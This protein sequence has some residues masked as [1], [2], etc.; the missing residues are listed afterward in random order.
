MIVVAI[1][2]ILAAIAV[3]AYQNYLIR[4]QVTEGLALADGWKTAVAEFYA[5]YGVF[6]S[7]ASATGAAPAGGGCGGSVAALSN[8][9]TGK[10]AT[11][12]VGA[13]GQIR[14]T[15]NGPQ[16]NA[17]IAGNV[18]DISPGGDADQDVVWICGK[19]AVP[20]TVNNPVPQADA[21][22][23]GLAPYLPTSCH[24]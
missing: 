22:T 8:T 2:G 15:Y 9:S 11:V 5:Q 20:A 21:T 12:T 19:A 13:C 18:L 14:I 23:P 3:P 16:V 1:I 4:S 17:K 10:Y 6:P 7:A 24:S